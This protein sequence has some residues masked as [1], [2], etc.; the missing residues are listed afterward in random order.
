MTDHPPFRYA[1]P[2]PA[3]RAEIAFALRSGEATASELAAAHG[4]S[5]ATVRRYATEIDVDR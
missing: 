5:D 2:D 1:I 3:L 4:I